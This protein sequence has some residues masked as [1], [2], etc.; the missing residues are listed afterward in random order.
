M[1]RRVVVASSRVL[2]M[3]VF[4]LSVLVM[5]SKC[6]SKSRARSGE[7][8][9]SV[10][11]VVLVVLPS[12]RAKKQKGERSEGM[13]VAGVSFSGV[14]DKFGRKNSARISRRR[15]LLILV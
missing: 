4:R 13:S 15:D 5:R 1:Q 9:V 3:S 10:V 8:G 7:S 14:L 2:G 12:A 6:K 11:L